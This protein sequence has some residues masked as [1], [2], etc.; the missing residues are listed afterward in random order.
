MEKKARLFVLHTKEA[1]SEQFIF[2]ALL[3]MKFLLIG[4]CL[5]KFGKSPQCHI[6]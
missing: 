4:K 6:L 5:N 1:Q 2:I 3:L